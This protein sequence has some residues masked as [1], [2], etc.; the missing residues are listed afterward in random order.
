MH[1]SPRLSLSRTFDADYLQPFDPSHPSITSFSKTENISMRASP[2]RVSREGQDPD[3]HQLTPPIQP[4]RGR[5]KLD[6]PTCD[7]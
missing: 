5:D 3:K 6:N 1:R 4:H 2:L 7:G